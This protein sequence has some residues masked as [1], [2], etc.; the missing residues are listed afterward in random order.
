MAKRTLEARGL[1]V[2]ERSVTY[3][4]LDGSTVKERRVTGYSSDGSVK[5]TY[6]E[7]SDGRSRLSI[8]LR[9]DRATRGAGR[10]AE[11]HGGSVDLEEG[12]RLYAVFN[13]VTP[14]RAEEIINDLLARRR[15]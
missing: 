12:E 7:F 15:P 3:Q 5:V 14:G 2:S 4:G 1:R 9:G 6:Q 13:N 10:R 11:A 8:L